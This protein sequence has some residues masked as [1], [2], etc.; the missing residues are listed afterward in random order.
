[1]KING[2]DTEEAC[3][4]AFHVYMNKTFGPDYQSNPSLSNSRFMFQAG[5][6]SAI[7]FIT[8]VLREK[9]EKPKGVVS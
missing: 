5:F 4:V 9:S 3:D 7:H 2:H 1:M 8:N 6:D